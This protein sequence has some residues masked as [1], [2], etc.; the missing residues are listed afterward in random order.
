VSL[1]LQWQGEPAPHHREI[2]Q[3]AN[4][5]DF[6]SRALDQVYPSRGLSF[7]PQAAT[8]TPLAMGGAMAVY[9]ITVLQPP[10]PYD[11]VGKIPQD[12]RIV[13]ASG[14]GHK[15]A[16]NTT[17]ALLERLV[18]LAAHLAQHAPGLFPRCGGVW[19]Q[20]QADGTARHLL[21]EEFIPGVSVER[22]K[23][24]YDEQL[25]RGELS[26]V[27]YQQRRTT[28]ERLAVA[29]FIRLWNCL[30]RCIFTSDPSPWNVL[31]RP[32]GVNGED[33]PAATIIDLHSLEEHAD[34]T[35][36]MQRLAAVYGMRQ[37]MLTEVILPGIFDVLG[38]EEGRAL[39]RSEL[40][41]LEAHARQTRQNLG[42]NLQQPLVNAIRDLG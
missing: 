30:G 20:H 38:L 41:Q 1:P 37:E 24:T 10:Q 8:I 13:Y 19:H 23:H 35:Y 11:L 31:L 17:H 39:L 21:V 12:R 40:P 25:V 14:T 29:A 18:A 15:T 16:D 36:V 2:I 4:D 42:V 22:L 32:S 34:L 7:S 28:V 9:K 26:T 33:S 3:T 6:L 5:D 27:A